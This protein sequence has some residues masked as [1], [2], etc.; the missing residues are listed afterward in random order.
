MVWGWGGSKEGKALQDRSCAELHGGEDGK[1]PICGG[2]WCAHLGWVGRDLV[3]H[4]GTAQVLLNHTNRDFLGDPVQPP[5]WVRLQDQAQGRSSKE[6]E[7]TQN[8]ASLQTALPWLHW[9][10]PGLAF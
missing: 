7:I 9:E 4:Q 3:P 8:L 1:E 6:G 2:L 5:V 10:S